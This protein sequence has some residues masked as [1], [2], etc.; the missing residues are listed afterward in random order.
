MT[1][2]A[3][4]AVTEG[5]MSPDHDLDR[6][7]HIAINVAEKIR[8]PGEPIMLFSELV[9]LCRTHPAKAAQLIMVYAA[10]LDLD[11]GVQTLWSRVAAI[12]YGGD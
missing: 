6:V 10:W 3:E 5:N 4:P 11:A 12:T 7:A 2:I 1:C 8:I 9:D